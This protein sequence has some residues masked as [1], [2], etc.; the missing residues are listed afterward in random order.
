MSMK[1]AIIISAVILSLS[2]QPLIRV[3]DRYSDTCVYQSLIGQVGIYKKNF[4]IYYKTMLRP[5][6]RV[7]FQTTDLNKWTVI[8][9]TNTDFKS[10]ITHIN[11]N[12]IKEKELT[13]QIDLHPFTK[14]MF[15]LVNSSYQPF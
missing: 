4:P 9:K 12:D 8:T 11:L 10:F 1:I 13:D 14:R 6:K 7:D 3:V 2:Y 15:E 5:L